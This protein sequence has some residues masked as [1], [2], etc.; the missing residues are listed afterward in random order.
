MSTSGSGERRIRATGFR[1]APAGTERAPARA[2]PPPRAADPP[3]PPGGGSGAHAAADAGLVLADALRDAAVAACRDAQAIDERVA[4]A[5][6]QYR[7]ALAAIDDPPAMKELASRAA[8]LERAARRRGKVGKL[9]AAQR[10]AHAAS[11]AAGV[12]DPAA[13]VAR[14]VELERATATAVDPGLRS[15]PPPLWWLFAQSKLD[16]FCADLATARALTKRYRDTLRRRATETRD[17]TVRTLREEREERKL[18]WQRE[19]ALLQPR[20][21][22]AAAAAEAVQPGWADAR[23]DD[24]TLPARP[25]GR[26]RVGTLRFPHRDAPWTMPLLWRCPSGPPLLLETDGHPRGLQHTL[27]PLVVRVLASLPAGAVETTLV[28]PVGLTETFSPL[29]H[30]GEYDARLLGERVV[31]EARDIEELLEDLTRHVAHVNAAFLRGSF[32][33]LEEHNAHAGSTATPYRLLVVAGFPERFSAE[34]VKRLA[35]I[36]ERG[37]AAGVIVVVHRNRATELP[38]GAELGPLAAASLRI[39]PAAIDAWNAW[40]A[41]AELTAPTCRAHWE[42]AADDGLDLRVEARADATRF[43]RLLERIGT[44][45]GGSRDRAVGMDDVLRRYAGEIADSPARHAG[46]PPIPRVGE[47]DSWWRGSTADGIVLPLGPAS[48]RATQTLVLGRKGTTRHHVL[49]AG[50]TGSGK[51]T[52]LRTLITVGAMIYPPE[53][54]R[55]ALIDFRNGVGFEIFASER[56][57]LLHADTIVVD[58]ERE[59]GIHLLDGLIAEMRDRERTIRAVTEREGRP[60]DDLAEYRR[61]TGAQMPRVLVLADEFQVLTEG[62]DRVSEAANAR[63]RTLAKQGRASG[64]HLLLASQTIRGSGLDEDVKK[65]AVVRIALQLSDVAESEALFSERNTAAAAL[66]Q[67]GAAILNAS[68]SRASDANEPFV[69]GLSDEPYMD[70]FLAGLAARGAGRPRTTRV[71]DGTGPTR[72]ER[73]LTVAR[74]L[75]RAAAPAA[76]EAE[77]APAAGAP[78]VRANFG[79]RAARTPA[80]APS[81][82]GGVRFGGAPPRAACAFG[83]AAPGV[84]DVR[85]A[86]GD[87]TSLR[88]PEPETLERRSAA[89]LL[90]VGG[91]SEHALGVLGGLVLGWLRSCGPGTG[92]VVTVLDCLRDE[93][94]AEVRA[95]VAASADGRV[96]WL[97]GR[98]IGP[99]LVAAAAELDARRTDET[100]RAPHL[101]AVLGLERADDLREPEERSFDPAGD[102]APP[103]PA[104]AFQALLVHGPR[105]GLHAA[106]WAEAAGTLGRM[107][108]YGMRDELGWVLAHRLDARG[109]E[110][111]VGSAAAA[112]LADGRALLVRPGGESEVLS[113]LLAPEDPADLRRLLAEAVGR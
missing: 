14:V 106:V 66:A 34:A 68:P 90:H 31:V 46:A 51:S 62:H 83:S 53:E 11:D 41:P 87:P 5:E 7:E 20:W 99:W 81:P 109:S 84:L 73:S 30:L 54:L 10:R 71:L 61:V 64:I 1:R 3:A 101:I 35:T 9:K 112:E 55:F 50:T 59:K 77:T 98:A 15:D 8:A 110:T 108:G 33:T 23:W 78:R 80:P 39:A 43:G 70:A 79:P 19:R 76:E 44:A 40:D 92:P 75:G 48:A 57:P 100:E 42:L 86:L 13:C 26:V 49:V 82:P 93:H 18:R 38:Y 96:A 88:P 36:A 95:A 12:T 105:T 21:A 65:Q 85:V 47:P 89:S 4:A 107:L 72:L 102:D 74:L 52:L 103:T 113:V 29:M 2:A 32:R 27:V 67:P 94:T 6:E 91:G 58:C 45:T 69:V 111:I 17:R 22:A 28:D 37:P 16:A 24:W 56:H 104:K 25:L 63:L 97:R 60:V